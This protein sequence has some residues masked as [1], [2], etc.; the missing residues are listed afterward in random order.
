MTVYLPNKLLEWQKLIP[1]G[2]IC[3]KLLF[4]FKGFQMSC[5]FT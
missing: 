1:A 4:E 3:D 5:I 2:N